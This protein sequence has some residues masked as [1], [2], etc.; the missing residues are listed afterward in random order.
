MGLSIFDDDNEE[1]DIPPI[2]KKNEKILDLISYV[3]AVSKDCKNVEKFV[4]QQK[5][6]LKIITK[7]LSLETSTQALLFSILFAKNFLKH[8]VSINQ[9]AEHLCI[10]PLNFAKHLEDIEKLKNKRLI[11]NSAFGKRSPNIN[12]WSLEIPQIIINRIIKNL[13]LQDRN[14]EINTTTDF[15][16]KISEYVD[17]IDDQTEYLTLVEN[18]IGL[19]NK[20]Q[21]IDFVRKVKEY[22]LSVE[23]WII[24][25]ALF[26]KKIIDNCG[27]DLH[28]LTKK[29]TQNTN[30]M[31]RLRNSLVYGTSMLIK[32]NILELAD[33]FMAEDKEIKMTQNGVYLFSE[34]NVS[35]Q[36]IITNKSREL[37]SHESIK[38]NPLIFNK[39]EKEQI[40]QVESLLHEENYNRVITN[41]NEKNFSCGL[42][43]L[44]HGTP[45]TGKSQSVLSLAKATQRDIYQVD[46]SEMRSMWY[47]QSEKQIKAIFQ[48][49][50]KLVEESE[51]VPIMYIDECDSV[52]TKR[53]SV[54]KSIDITSNSL[55]NILLLEIQNLKGILIASCNMTN[56]DRAF[57]RRFLFKIKFEKPSIETRKTIWLTKIPQ[58]ETYVI[59]QLSS[60]DFSGGEIDNV[61]RKYLLQEIIDG[62]PP[63][64]DELI[65]FCNQERFKTPQRNKIGY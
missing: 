34:K 55:Q 19:L 42:T 40:L 30:A 28:N 3:S 60:Y 41:L 6:H 2:P 59:E 39:K 14:S 54:E 16:Q 38:V 65:N 63:S 43:M 37:I 33:G 26:Y 25:G 35:G 50:R 11:S 23:E 44:F 62:C 21:H 1:I 12:S 64:F 13:P 4:V 18:A 36:G 45:G 53:I 49:Y 7:F 32:K 31:I 58:L 27:L 15:V 52:I 29:V 20:H 8:S 9:V 61:A 51:K 5:I 24:V 57:E 10:K 17:E 56:F 47:G 46:I 48:T 22:N